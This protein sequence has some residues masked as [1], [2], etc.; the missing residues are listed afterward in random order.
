MAKPTGCTSKK[1]INF[2]LGGRYFSWS[3]AISDEL[4]DLVLF[5]PVMKERQILVVEELF[6]LALN[7]HPF[8]FAV[9]GC[10]Q[11]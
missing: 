8:Q 1:M 7:C 9:P 10:V 2:W 5:G 4:T 11:F 6:L 3:S